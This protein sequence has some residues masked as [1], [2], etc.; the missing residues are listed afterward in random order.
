MLNRLL[1][2]NLGLQGRTVV[3]MA[4]NVFDHV[5]TPTQQANYDFYQCKDASWKSRNPAGAH[6]SRLA[7]PPTAAPPGIASFGVCK[8]GPPTTHHRPVDPRGRTDW[9]RPPSPCMA[10]HD[11]RMTRPL[12]LTRCAPPAAALAL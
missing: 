4:S 1:R 10:H 9:L 6:S 11:T 2:P 5:L 7:T 12:R 3:V 8:R